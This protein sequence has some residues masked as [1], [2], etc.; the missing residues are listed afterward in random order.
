MA[1]WREGTGG[2]AVPPQT[3]SFR[4]QRDNNKA[5]PIQAPVPTI[6]SDFGTGD[7]QLAVLPAGPSRSDEAWNVDH[8]RTKEG[9]CEPHP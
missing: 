6:D 7:Q 8:S 4:E 2:G 3:C 9:G 5:I 1:Q